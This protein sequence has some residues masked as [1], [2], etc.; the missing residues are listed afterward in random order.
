MRNEDVCADVAMSIIVKFMLAVV[1]AL[2]NC[3]QEQ[4]YLQTT[5]HVYL[6]ICKVCSTVSRSMYFFLTTL[7]AFQ[8]NAYDVHFNQSSTRATGGNLIDRD[9]T[10]NSTPEP[11]H[12]SEYPLV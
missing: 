11:I 10:D 4:R 9:R 5:K 7:L 1:M 12:S 8:I 6:T 2:W 3:Q